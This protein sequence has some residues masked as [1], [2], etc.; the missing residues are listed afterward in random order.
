MTRPLH[1]SILQEG[2]LCKFLPLLLTHRLHYC[3]E[4]H[5]SCHCDN[6]L[7][8]WWSLLDRYSRYQRAFYCQF[9]FLFLSHVV[10]GQYF[11]FQCT[12]LTFIAFLSLPDTLNRIKICRI[13]CSVRNCS[14]FLSSIPSYSRGWF[15]NIFSSFHQQL[16]W[17]NGLCT[18]KLLWT[19][20]IKDAYVFE[21]SWIENLNLVLLPHDCTGSEWRTQVGSTE[22]LNVPQYWM[23]CEKLWC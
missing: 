21:E 16:D 3:S 15:Q 19:F 4:T 9:Y 14:T 2:T 10:S 6:E 18:L 22:D 20:M 11:S 5:N 7:N 8:L 12:F 13:N 17:Y 23:F 1:M